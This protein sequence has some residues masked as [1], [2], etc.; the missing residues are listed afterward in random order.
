MTNKA[1]SSHDDKQ[2]L[3]NFL[4]H[5]VHLNEAH[6]SRPSQNSIAEAAKPKLPNI[7]VQ[8]NTSNI[9]QTMS[10]RAAVDIPLLVTSENASS[11]RRITPSW[12]IEQLKGRLEPISG[13]PASC[14]RL[15]LRV[16]S[17][18][19]QP[20]EAADEASTQLARWP[21]QAY[22]EIHVGQEFT[23]PLSLNMMRLLRPVFDSYSF[24]PAKNDDLGFTSRIRLM[25]CS[26]SEISCY[27]TSLPCMDW[28]RQNLPQVTRYDTGLKDTTQLSIHLSLFCTKCKYIVLANDNV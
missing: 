4:K 18:T 23:F 20:I 10:S 14:Q 2:A 8:A 28:L 27:D 17:Q 16:G 24:L 5:P 12:T 21:L 11:E 3:P 6:R 25:I 22:A 7:S 19:P 13:I 26:G 9:A 1:G 15:T